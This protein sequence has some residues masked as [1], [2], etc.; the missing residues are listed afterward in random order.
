MIFKGNSFAGSYAAVRFQREGHDVITVNPAGKAEGVE[1]SAPHIEYSY[2]G[3]CRQMEEIVKREKPEV[4]IISGPERNG[5]NNGAISCAA[6]I[7]SI[8]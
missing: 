4:I 7:E 2:T 1:F 3:N 6:A 5:G 8:L